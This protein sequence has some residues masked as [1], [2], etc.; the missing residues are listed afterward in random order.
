MPKGLV[1]SNSVGSGLDLEEEKE[2]NDAKKTTDAKNMARK[3]SFRRSTMTGKNH[4]LKMFMQRTVEE[5]QVAETLKTAQREKL[6]DI[7]KKFQNIAK[8]QLKVTDS[9]IARKSALSVVPSGAFSH[10][11]A[12]ALNAKAPTLGANGALAS[13]SKPTLSR[14]GSAKVGSGLETEGAV[15]VLD[16]ANRMKELGTSFRISKR[17]LSVNSQ[18]S[19]RNLLTRTNS[20]VGALSA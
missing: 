3:P 5:E 8:E 15:T 9:A 13:S 17:Q 1:R 12:L 11:A 16:V 18:S 7:K 4:A 2:A 19:Q 20:N 14:A 6:S 10:A